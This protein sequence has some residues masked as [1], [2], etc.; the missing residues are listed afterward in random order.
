MYP[1][2]RLD[3]LTDG[4]MAVAMTLLVLDLRLPETL[5]PTTNAEFKE[6]LIDLLPKFFPYLLSFWVLGTGW[7]SSI[8]IR[9]SAEFVSKHYTTWWLLHLMFVTCIPFTTLLVGRYAQFTLAT[10][11][12]AASLALSAITSYVAMSL[13][14]EVQRDHNWR[15]RQ[16]S[17]AVLV[18]SALLTIT[19]SFSSSEY[20][21]LAFLLNLAAPVIIRLTK[22]EDGAK[23]AGEV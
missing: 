19:I 14:P 23:I 2:S 7:L 5:H 1:R 4:I 20:A 6:A 16:I 9:T 21:P 22:V 10:S 12:Y 11:L 15:A 8:K 18:V 17:L 3:A 13:L